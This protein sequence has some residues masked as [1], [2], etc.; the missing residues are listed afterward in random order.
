MHKTILFILFLFS[1]IKSQVNHVYQRPPKEILELV[2][3]SLPPR[4]LIDENKKFIVHLYRDSYKSIN[5]LSVPEIKLAGLRL[6]PKSNKR[7][8]KKS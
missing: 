1:I 3:V 8:T 6:N 4:V 7:A 2:D 5:E